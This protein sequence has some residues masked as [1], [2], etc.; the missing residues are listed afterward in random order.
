[1]IYT[2]GRRLAVNIPEEAV[3]VAEEWASQDIEIALAMAAPHIIAAE[4]ERLADIK[5]DPIS[6]V[7][8]VWLKERAAEL[9]GES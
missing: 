6:R 8:S 2:E 3:E 9:R 5:G 1:M 7:A 4:L